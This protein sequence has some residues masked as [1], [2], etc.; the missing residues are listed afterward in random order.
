MEA[1]GLDR[2]S[3]A[4]ANPNEPANVEGVE[5]EKEESSRKREGGV[6]S[7]G[8]ISDDAMSRVGE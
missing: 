6:C 2:V 8:Y 7:Y 5:G 1:A 4:A 3:A